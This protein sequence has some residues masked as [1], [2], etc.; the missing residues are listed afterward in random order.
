MPEF[1]AKVENEQVV[2]TR[3]PRQDKLADGRYVSNYHLLP[4]STLLSEG[5]LPGINSKPSYDPETEGLQGPSYD[6]QAEQVVANYTAIPKPEPLPVVPSVLSIGLTADKTEITA[7][8][9]DA[10]T[11]TATIEG[12]EVDSIPCYV[13]VNG[14]P[15][16]EA[17]V[18]SGQ[19]VREFATTE[20]GLFRV[21]YFCG[22]KQATIFIKGV[23]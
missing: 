21:D 6:I 23:A 3:L 22:D 2:S 13:T 4:E 9:E 19:V 12:T 15:A 14:P 20:V 18:I 11:V 8:G 17:E 1:W 16:E 5:W 7:D 10:V